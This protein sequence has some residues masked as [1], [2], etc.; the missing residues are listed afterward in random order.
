MIKLVTAVSA[1][2]TQCLL[3]R[4]SFSTVGNSLSKLTMADTQ[5]TIYKDQLISIFRKSVESVKPKTLFQSSKCMKLINSHVL[6]ISD[7]ASSEIINIADKQCHLVG[8][9]KAVLGMSIQIERIFGDR[10][11]SAIISVPFGTK[12]TFKFDSDMQLCSNSCIQVFEGARN[13]LPDKDAENT[14]KRILSHVK[15]LGNEDILF[16]VISGGGSALIPLP[17]PPVTL[18][19]KRNLIKELASKKATINEINAVRIELSQIKGGKLIKAAS[20]THRV[21]SLIISDVIGDPLDIIASGPTVC[22]RSDSNEIALA[23]LKK[24]D[25][26][27]SIPDTIRSVLLSPDKQKAPDHLTN[28]KTLIIGNNKLATETA[29]SEAK[30]QGF[31]TICL[32]TKVQGNVEELSK[33]YLYLIQSIYEYRRETIDTIKLQ[34][35]LKELNVLFEFNDNVLDELPL[36]LRSS[37]NQKPICLVAGGEPTVFI[38]GNGLGGRSQE[39]ALRIS[40]LLA[41]NV[42]LENVLFLAAGTDGIDGPANAA[43]AIGCSQVIK[44]FQSA[45][46]NIDVNEYIQNNDSFNFYRNVSDGKYHIIT[47]HTGTNVMDLHL[48]V[49]PF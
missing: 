30:R 40:S 41:G 19:D 5:N 17:I 24:Y 32:S 26:F 22:A 18:D 2:G 44:D 39:L 9:G 31:Q 25:V 29:L 46:S 1:I 45:A 28:S 8:F 23:V 12:E 48:V 10:L 21:I 4:S 38:Q 20:N 11:K 34:T 37:S 27:N 42:S 33:A 36:L 35:V 49:I 3:L 7:G 13:N 15:T 14:A 47:G 6:E 16:V 43:G